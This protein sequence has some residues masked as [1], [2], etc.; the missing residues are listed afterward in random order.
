MLLLMLL[1]WVTQGQVFFRQ[2]RPG[3]NEVPFYIFKFAKMDRKGERLTPVGRWIQRLS[4]DELPQLYN[5]LIGDMSLVGPRPLLMEYLPRYS[6]EERKR[7]HVMPGITGWAQVHG[8]TEISFKERFQMD[9][10]YVEH[11][12]FGL[13]LKIL[14]MT[15]S[16]VLR[17]SESRFDTE[18]FD[19]KN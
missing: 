18:R 19:G 6:E 4:L 11:K 14:W 1:L 8:R 16:K 13:D 15:L 12:S 2:K 9:L 17:S 10:W 3:K 5:V 7:H